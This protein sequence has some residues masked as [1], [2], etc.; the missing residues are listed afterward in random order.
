MNKWFTTLT[1]GL[2][3]ATAAQAQLWPAKPVSQKASSERAAASF[4]AEV[5]YLR[6]W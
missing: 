6:V 5:V 3:V 2:A 1:L 4:S